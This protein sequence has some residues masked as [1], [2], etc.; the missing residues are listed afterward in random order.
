[1]R[2]NREKNKIRRYFSINATGI[3]TEDDIYTCSFVV[4]RST[5]FIVAVG[6]IVNLSV[7]FE[8]RYHLAEIATR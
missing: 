7:G 1:M 2:M 5:D 3:R 4:D 8:K 6:L